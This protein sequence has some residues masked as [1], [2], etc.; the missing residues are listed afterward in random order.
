MLQ[1]RYTLRHAP[2]ASVDTRAGVRG[3]IVFPQQI[4]GMQEEWMPGV[5]GQMVCD[6]LG[7]WRV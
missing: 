4:L 7:Q 3:A 1:L 5:A 6:D 2:S